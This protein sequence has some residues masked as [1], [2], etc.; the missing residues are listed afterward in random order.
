MDDNIQHE[1]DQ[2]DKRLKDL[3]AG[4]EKLSLEAL[5]ELR[6]E[7]EAMKARQNSGAQQDVR[8][9]YE[10]PKEEPRSESGSVQ[11]S[12]GR[13]AYGG[14][15]QPVGRG[16]I[17]QIPEPS[18]SDVN[19]EVRDRK[20][21]SEIAV[22]KYVVGILA[23]LLVLLSVCVAIGSSWHRIPDVVKFLLVMT[24][25]VILTGT[26]EYMILCKNTGLNGF[27][28]SIGACGFMVIFCDIVAGAVFWFLYGAGLAGVFFAVWFVACFLCAL[29]NRSR[30]FY[31]V[32]Y[33]GGTLSMVLAVST[34]QYGRGFPPVLDQALI[35]MMPLAVMGVGLV[36][37]GALND[38]FL[39]FLNASFALASVGILGAWVPWQEF[40]LQVSDGIRCEIL[41]FIRILLAVAAIY[42]AQRLFMRD[43]KGMA[44]LRSLSTFGSSCV[45]F[46]C[47]L[48]MVPELVA[49]CLTLVVLFLMFILLGMPS[50]MALGT[51]PVA[52]YAVC[53]MGMAVPEIGSL[54]PAVFAVVALHS[55]Y[56]MSGKLKELS[57]LLFSAVSMILACG[58]T[59]DDSSLAVSCVTGITGACVAGCIG[60]V[61]RN[62]GGPLPDVYTRLGILIFTGAISYIY[63]D[64][65]YMPDYCSALILV[66]ICVALVAYRYDLYSR[67]SMYVPG[68]MVVSTGLLVVIWLWCCFWGPESHLLAVL[69][70]CAVI[71][72]VPVAILCI[73]FREGA[74]GFAIQ[75][76]IAWCDVGMFCAM[77][78][79]L[80]VETMAICGL[81][82]ICASAAAIAFGFAR[83]RKDIR[84][85]GLTLTIIH[86]LLI[87]G[88]TA[89]RSGTIGIVLSLLGAGIV[90]FGISFAY[91]KLSAVYDDVD[92]SE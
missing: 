24:G 92:S 39:W 42:C 89:M 27:W 16:G 34:T 64:R 83:Q 43:G 90:C 81:V 86:V 45:L 23:A 74:K 71:L 6:R 80:G 47:F 84:V 70:W 48:D 54:V 41:L 37:A 8:I 73:A 79:G 72:G 26:G 36:A 12:R 52:A 88:S 38:G 75:A 57:V 20:R 35:C 66:A 46:V 85:T 9:Q 2:I 82:M 22:G 33:L 44:F 14:L 4:Q 18:R 77:R 76:A 3:E 31:L 13:K 7:V 29:K 15:R 87:A 69:L 10:Q 67:E 21:M 65:Y 63:A 19:T 25:G 62:D 28:Q 51:A 49:C 11:D 30:L 17:G 58:G 56:G 5:Y 78:S 50:V 60:Y 40:P 53:G 68:A 55:Q 1:L 32:S 59:L 61:V 91:N